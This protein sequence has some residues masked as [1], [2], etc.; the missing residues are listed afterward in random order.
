MR[1]P[2]RS[3]KGAAYSHLTAANR[4]AIRKILRD[5]KRDLP[6]YFS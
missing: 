2:F 3:R 5:T 1:G 4:V 6:D